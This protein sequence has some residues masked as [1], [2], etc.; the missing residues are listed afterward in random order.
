MSVFG[1]GRQKILFSSIFWGLSTLGIKGEKLNFY[2]S[3]IHNSSLVPSTLRK[4][5][6]KKIRKNSFFG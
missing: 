1:A 6:G 3:N 5:E 4:I 2:S